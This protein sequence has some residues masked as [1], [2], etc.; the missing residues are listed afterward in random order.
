MRGRPLSFD[1]LTTV[2]RVI[3]ELRNAPF[4]SFEQALNYVG[5]LE[6]CGLQVDPSIVS[7]LIEDTEDE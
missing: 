7:E 6:T 1:Q 3:K 2:W 5:E 4:V